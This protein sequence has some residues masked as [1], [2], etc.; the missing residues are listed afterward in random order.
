MAVGYCVATPCINSYQVFIARCAERIA[1]IRESGNQLLSP[2][3][4]TC[5]ELTKNDAECCRL[6]GFE[7]R[8][9]AAVRG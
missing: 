5:L 9:Q 1:P 7:I 4:I 2:V 6:D 3:G 8:L